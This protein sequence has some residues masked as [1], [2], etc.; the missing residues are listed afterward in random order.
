L[1]STRLVTDSQANVRARHD[2]MP[3]GEEISAGI[4]G[5]TSGQGYGATDDTRQKFTSKERD[6]ESGL[7]YFGARYYSSMQGRFTSVDPELGS[8]KRGSP[9]TWNRYSYCLNNPLVLVDPDGKDVH[10]LD[11]TALQLLREGLPENIRS[12]VVLDNNGLID[13][14]ALNKID[15]K[16][17]NF[18]DLKEMVNAKG[19]VD[20]KSA[21]EDEKGGAFFYDTPEK[22]KKE[23]IGNLEKFGASKEEIAEEQAK[24]YKPNLRLG[25]TL[26]AKE[27]PTGNIL[28]MVANGTGRSADAPRVELVTTTAHELLGHAY[29]AQQGKPWLHEDDRNGPVNS[30]TRNVEDRAERNYKVSQQPKPQVKKP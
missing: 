3:F 25:R 9:E 14:E 1:G 20:F 27:S 15:S 19:V 17:E 21:S 18:L 28:V 11:D 8:A 10:V 6:N 24:E 12:Q 29:L 2:Y 5:R 13:K 26:D 22:V 7:D 23:V 30:R 4:G 16:D